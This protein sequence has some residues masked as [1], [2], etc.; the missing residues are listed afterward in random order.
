MNKASRVDGILDAWIQFIQLEDF[1]NAQVDSD[2][3]QWEGID[4]V[5]DKVL[6]KQEIFLK[7][8]E[9]NRQKKQWCLSFPQIYKVEKGR[10]K[11][12][13]LFCLDISPILKSSYQVEGWDIKNCSLTEARDNL[14]SLFQLEEEQLDQLITKEGLRRFLETTFDITFE[15]FEHWMRQFRIPGYRLTPKPYLFELKGGNFSSNL[16]KDL[17]EIRH[18]QNKHWLKLRHP[19]YEYLFGIPHSPEHETSY[20]GA[21]PTHPP[22]N[23]QLKALKHAQSEPLTVVQGPPGSGK[24]TL[25][26]HL[27]AQQVVNRALNLIEKS[28][29]TN[30]LTVVSSAN[31]QAIENVIERFQECLTEPFFYLRG[32]PQRVINGVDGA[33]ERLDQ[34]LNYLREHSCNENYR[35]SLISQIKQLKQDLTERE[36]EFRII[37]QKRQVDE[38]RKP[39]LIKNIQLLQ[40]QL[41]EVNA[42]KIQLKDRLNSLADLE[43]LPEKLYKQIWLE[44]N[45]TQLQLS[46]EKTPQWI[47][48]FYSILGKN[49]RQ[50]LAKMVLKVKD[51]IRQTIGTKFEIELPTDRKI[52]YQQIQQIEEKLNRLKELRS[53]QVDLDKIYNKINE[54]NRKIE[55][56]K[57]ELNSINSRL[58]TPLQDLY[59][60]FHVHYHEQHKILFKLSRK[61]LL[62]EALQ[63]KEKIES[64]LK[65][66]LNTL[67]PGNK[68]LK[69]FRPMAEKLDEHLKA[70]S[71]M[72]PVITCTL[73]S[74]RNMLPWVKE[75]VDRV[76][77]DEAGMIP[78]HQA[79][80]LLV[81]SRKAIIVGDP[82]QIEPIVTQ[83]K[84]TLED[85]FDK[86]F[87]GRGLT[88][89]DYC[90]YSP[91]QIDT[92]TTYHRAAGASGEENDLGQGIRLLEHYR[93]Q[94][95]II[96]FCDR[97]AKYGLIPK[98]K[99]EKSRIGP[100]LIA[101][102]IDGKITANVNQDEVTAIQKVIQHL[103]RYGYSPEEIGVVSAFRAQA[104]A[105]R[106]T[107]LNSFPGLENA[108]GT[109]HKFQGSERRVI[110]LSTKVCGFQ[111]SAAWI[112]RRPNLL[113]VAVSRAKELFILVGNLHR[114]EEEGVYTRQLV[115]HIR[116]HGVILEYKPQSDIN[117]EDHSTSENPLVY[118]CDHLEILDNAIRES[119]QEL[120][121]VI[122]QVRGDAAY[123]FNQDIKLAL[124][125]GIKVTVIYGSEKDRML[126][127]ENRKHRLRKNSRNCFL[128]ILVQV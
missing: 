10:P 111:D 25:I 49:E 17:K 96:E 77:I 59:D 12:C 62:Q 44:F 104:D 115:E 102:H 53:A 55:S 85:Y 82:L 80:P 14:A 20:L 92:A 87:I 64:G 117:L 84:Q 33:R 57:K 18:S 31:N 99:T 93:C 52:L 103:I 56:Q 4:L 128:G 19:A 98:A 121:I 83:S 78:L 37:R 9:N 24:T 109:V 105:L 5:G 15:S 71:L 68:N 70:I 60:T 114:L 119:K 8:Q 21:F 43:H 16:K 81:R 89:E 36:L 51:L 66:Y 91:A 73:L 127:N 1:R 54:F 41:L 122:P 32:G 110:L 35:N 76:I 22:T 125:R 11:Y 29:D 75:C 69:P 26:L 13:P 34:A 113:N 39:Q 50:I 72:F 46:E 88:K 40:Q 27:I 74:I 63:Q 7:L 45:S 106:Q 118:D 61:F 97:I 86:A 6:I 48:W 107:L 95:R 3:T 90:R 100:N 28:Q 108:I 101:Y 23:S 116:K 38:A 2:K 123:R 42:V 47:G 79:F 112:N 124:K 120:Y 67:P 94:P 30:K 58:E 65:L 126:Q